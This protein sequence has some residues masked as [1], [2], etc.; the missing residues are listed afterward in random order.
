[1]RLCK[2]VALALALL[3]ALCGGFPALA[4][5]RA[6]YRMPYYITV[7]IENQI[8]TVYDAETDRVARQMLCSTGK[9]DITPTGTFIMPRRQ[10]EDR[11]PW[12]Y[13]DMY[14]RYVRYASRIVDQILFHSLPYTRQSLQSIDAKAAEEL[15]KPTSHG[16]IR[17]RWQDAAFIAQRC[18][19]GTAVK[20]FKGAPLDEPLRQLLRL[21]SYDAETGL[22]YESFLGVSGE[23]GA[24]S[25][26]S[27]GPEVLNLQYRLRDLG[28][29]AGALNGVYDAATVNAVRMAQYLSG[30]ELSGVASAAYQKLLYGPD[31][32]VAM[33]VALKE[34]MSGPA[35]RALQRNL[36]A[37]QLYDGPEDGVYDGDVERA[38]QPF[39]QA[40]GYEGDGTASPT[41]QKA[42]AW[43]AA[44]L[45]ETFGSAPYDCQRVTDP[46]A[47]ARV[48]VREGARLREGPSQDSR[49][50]DRLAQDRVMIVLQRG[51]AWAFVQS[52]GDTGYV[53]ND[54][55]TF[56]ERPTTLLKYAAQGEDLV[57]TIGSTAEDYR[58]GAALPCEVFETTLAANDRHVDLDSLANYVTVNTGEG[59]PGLNLR[60]T[61]EADGP[62][63]EVL[64]NGERLPAL[65]RG[66]EWTLVRWRGRTG[67]LM[68]R[69][70]TFW[71]GPRDALDGAL[72]ATAAQLPVIGYA[73]V[74]S[75]TGRSAA[76]YEDALDGARV[77]GHLD[78]GVRVAVLEAADGWCMIR[79][80]GREGF[81]A[82]EDL[83]PED[84]SEG[85]P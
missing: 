38:L 78:N 13:I 52:G 85:E 33:E 45:A 16:C 24:L 63:M 84:S 68:N 15:G 11:K 39:L 49:Q 19:P 8:V 5:S 79:H 20:I 54:L 1:M 12:Y 4:L 69:Y 29:Y 31:A 30:D 9:S 2:T 18:L 59:G 72:D 46:L 27:E 76:V 34:G 22:S 44:R 73:A 25:R 62:V 58:S 81:M 37:L 75:A 50:V 74:R 83:K 80:E 10:N 51:E 32:P 40:Y 55:V 36:A 42:L 7:D 26:A 66:V 70:L 48:S 60:Q 56:F 28:L 14:R 6:D 23:E 35:V 71:T 77:L 61:P 3:L 53:R 82:A 57:Y 47:L 21:Q 41:L 64:Q 65:R 17:L 67:Y 43:E